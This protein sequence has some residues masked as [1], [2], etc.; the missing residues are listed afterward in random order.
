MLEWKDLMKELGFEV[1]DVTGLEE[2]YRKGNWLV[3]ATRQ[4]VTVWGLGV[5]GPV[6]SEFLN[7]TWTL[8]CQRVFPSGSAA[9]ATDVRDIRDMLLVVEAIAD[10]EK[11]PLLL[12]EADAVVKYWAKTKE[13]QETG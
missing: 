1:L 11:M 12:G 3:T 7:R 2:R 5:V 4:Q 6:T 8:L 10:P 9:R 13:G